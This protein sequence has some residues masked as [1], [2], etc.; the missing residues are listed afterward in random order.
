MS[1]PTLTEVLESGVFAIAGALAELQDS[2]PKLVEKGR[3]NLEPKLGMAKFVGQFAVSRLENEV[4]K[5]TDSAVDQIS[6]LLSLVFGTRETQQQ[7]DTSNSEADSVTENASE[8]PVAA[9]SNGFG[10]VGNPDADALPI[11]GYRTL[12]AQQIIAR[13]DSL[14]SRELDQIEQYES[15][16][17]NRASILRSI[18]AKRDRS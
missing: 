15:R 9:R 2:F 1:K 4:H 7:P 5:R 11:S 13:L 14:N 6:E 12:S 18:A 17:R 16:H 3:S 8:A 10:G